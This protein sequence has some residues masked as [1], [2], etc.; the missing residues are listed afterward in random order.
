[1]VALLASALLHCV[2]GE[3]P[4]DTKQ[5]GVLVLCFLNLCSA[6]LCCEVSLLAAVAFAIAFRMAAAA[7]GSVAG[8]KLPRLAECDVAECDAEL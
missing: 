4:G 7:A 5:Y 1:M 2:F 6:A 8:A 3:T